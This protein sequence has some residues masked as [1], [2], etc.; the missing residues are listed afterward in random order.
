MTAAGLRDAATLV[1]LREAEPFEIL[2]IAR[3]PRGRVMAGFW[4][5]PG[6]VLEPGDGVG[7]DGVRAAAVRELAEET[8]ITGVRAADLVPFARWITPISAPH[9]FDTLFFLGRAPHGSAASA[10]GIEA[11]DAGWFSPAAALAAGADGSRPL[12]FPTR[13]TLE[14]VMAFA[15]IDEL[16][17][18][19]ASRTVEPIQPRLRLPLDG[20]DPLLPGEP[21]YDAATG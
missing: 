5:F 16:L 3:N 4:V 9:R 21:G 1:L 11:V 6:G 13:R 10:D 2:M 18:D 20:R 19:A 17:A 12:M 8:A 14:R 7:E 15:S